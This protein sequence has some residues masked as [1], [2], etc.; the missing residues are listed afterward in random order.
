MVVCLD[1]VMCLQEVCVMRE[2]RSA[3]VIVD[4]LELSVVRA[5]LLLV[6]MVFVL[7]MRVVVVV[8]KTVVSVQ[9][10]LPSLFVM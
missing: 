2:I 9:A 4:V 10:I 3:Q 7:F 6:E 5:S 1:R 8:L